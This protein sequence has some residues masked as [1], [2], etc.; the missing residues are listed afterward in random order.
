M[1][2]PAMQCVMTVKHGCTCFCLFR[3]A[4]LFPAD[5]SQLCLIRRVYC[6]IELP[7]LVPVTFSPSIGHIP[8]GGTKDIVVTYTSDKPVQ[9]KGAQ[10]NIKA[11]QINIAPGATQSEWD[12]RAD[13]SMPSAP[14]P[15]VELANPKEAPPVTLPLKVRNKLLP[16]LNCGWHLL[17]CI[18]V[19][20][21][22]YSTCRF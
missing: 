2:Q 7:V 21:T 12:N 16:C 9:L 15:K 17:T 11:T 22:M 5:L 6:R 18:Y 1:S 19:A 10:A 8:A 14:E 4:G 3:H 13:P 20:H